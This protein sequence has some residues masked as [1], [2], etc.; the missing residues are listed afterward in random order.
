[1][2]AT[3]LRCGID[4]LVCTHALT[5][6]QT[7]DRPQPENPNYLCDL[8]HTFS[9]RQTLAAHALIE[10]WTPTSLSLSRSARPK[11]PPIMTTLSF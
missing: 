5:V 4:P 11:F 3:P 7:S 1:L 9:Y 8:G 2:G 10:S 6:P